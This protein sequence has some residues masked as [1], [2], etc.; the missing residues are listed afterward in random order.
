MT[1]VGLLLMASLMTA[2][3]VRPPAPVRSESVEEISGIVEAVDG[4]ARIVTLRVATGDAI[5]V[6]VATSA[7]NL[8]QFR[9]GDRIAIRFY[10]VLAAALRRRGDASGETEEPVTTADVALATQ[11][12]QPGGVVGKQVHQ[13]VRVTAVNNRNHFVTFYGHDGISRSLPVRTPEGREFISRLRVGDE[14]DVTYTE[15]LAI[16]VEPGT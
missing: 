13:T 2:C 8:A 12:A 16:S 1:K 15:G 3:A 10:T 7:R 14:V 11:N 4:E 6:P 9:V 5:D